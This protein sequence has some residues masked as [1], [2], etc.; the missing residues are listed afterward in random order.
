MS[1]SLID[2]GDLFFFFPIFPAIIVLNFIRTHVMIRVSEKASRLKKTPSP[3]EARCWHIMLPTLDASRK[4]SLMSL[5]NSWI[6]SLEYQ[7]IN[8]KRFYLF[9]SLT[10]YIS[11]YRYIVFRPPRTSEIPNFGVSTNHDDYSMYQN[12][13][14]RL[15]DSHMIDRQTDRHKGRQ[16]DIPNSKETHTISYLEKHFPFP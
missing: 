15:T 2:K 16:T 9:S 14:E 13:I 1:L 6:L 7:L 12:L 8:Y 4:V 10:H 5:G 3:G 11:V